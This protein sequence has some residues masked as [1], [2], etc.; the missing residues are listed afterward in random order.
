MI[1][2]RR[3][4]MGYYIQG[5]VTG[6][7]AFLVSEYDAKYIEKPKSYSDIPLDKALI[8]VVNN[9]FFE[10]AAYCYSEAKLEELA[11]SG[12]IRPKQWMVMDKLTAEKL[13]DFSQ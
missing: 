6:K 9:G 13:T 2:K 10:A 12:D 8:C 3:I 1:P 4:I 7:A 11:S 5:P